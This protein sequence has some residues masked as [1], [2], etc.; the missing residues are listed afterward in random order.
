MKAFNPKSCRELIAMALAFIF[1]LQSFSQFCPTSGLTSV[2]TYPNT[3]Y[4]A[5]QASA[6]SGSTSITLGPAGYG[7]H[8][9]ALGD[10][11]LVMQ[12]QGADF[13][14]SNSSNYGSGS[15]VGRGYNANANLLAGNFEFVIAENTVP[16]TGG[17]LT[18]A[19][20]LQHSYEKQAYS[21]SGTGQ[22]TYQV[23]YIPTYY[24]LQLGSNVS[25]PA[26]NGSTGGVLIFV[27]G[28][29]FN[30]NG[31]T[32][33]GS[34]TGFRGGAT[35]ML[36]GGTGDNP[37]DY[38]TLSTINNNAGKGEG[39]AGT[40]RFLNNAGFLLDNGS[41]NEG[42]PNGAEGRGAPGNAGGGGTDYDPSANDQNDGGGGGGKGGIGG[43]GGNSWST[44]EPV[45]G[46]GG[47]AFS[48]VSPSR[49]VMGGGGGGGTNNNGTGGGGQGFYSSGVAG[50]GLVIIYTGTF[51]APSGSTIN[52]NGTNGYGGVLNDGSGG[53]G[54]GGSVL[55]FAGSSGSSLTN[56]RVTA[57]GGNGGSNT[58][59]GAKHGPGGGGAGG[60]IYSNVAIG[61]T[62]INGGSPG[63]TAGSSFYNATS[64]SSGIVKQNVA[65][66]SITNFPVACDILPVNFLSFTAQPANGI[67]TLSWVIESLTAKD[68]S[69]ERSFD[70]NSF[71]ALGTVTPETGNNP[72][73]SYSYIDN[74]ATSPTGTLY[75]R[76]REE[77]ETGKSYY[78]TVVKLTTSN[79]MAT[80]GVYPNPAR[81]SFTLTFSAS[82]AGAVSLR[83]FD[84]AGRL[85]LSQ[86]FQA[87]TGV[88]AVTM[89]GL[90][91]LPEGMYIL[92]W[93][94]G[95][96]PRT[97]KVLIRH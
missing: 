95:L 87:S 15:G 89:G 2:T 37:T 23:I 60:V 85:V 41:S 33:N 25:V 96:Q 13:D 5:T 75:Y 46:I 80:S 10:I 93:Y 52:V 50:G 21:N 58:G 8:A 27:A 83:L 66:S 88:N 32:I 57:N 74:N 73:K 81:E 16:T 90:G 72:T 71:N 94:D 62:T 3:Y 49:L 48:Q 11:L 1:H 18:L 68:Y 4:P 38:T 64:G 14:T 51:T 76:I 35:R 9:I 31:Y 45:G 59:N 56:L 53:G 69:V 92:Q 39:I 36:T 26:W 47:A 70:G 97:S 77:D 28:D 63:V 19:Y 91:T 40:P 79:M 34:G 6:P 12:M 20:P 43:G 65:T 67:A 22:Y 54:A 7:S 84:L 24:D 82:A 30:F 86:P 78:S 44:N 42:Y 55:L 61:T 17:T 29:N